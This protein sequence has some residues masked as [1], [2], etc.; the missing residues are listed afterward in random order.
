[1]RPAVNSS[2]R[3]PPLG[4]VLSTPAGQYRLEASLCLSSAK[5]LAAHHPYPNETPHYIIILHSIELGLKAFLIKSGVDVKTLSKN[6]YR[7]DL[8]A[9]YNEA[10]QRGLSLGDPNAGALIAWVNEWHCK[11]VK[12]RYEFAGERD[13][14]MCAVLIPLAE[15][16]ITACEL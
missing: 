5:T 8:C 14:P 4:K 12:I 15:A 6:P 16:I 7:H 13:L 1:M 2:T 10:A 9:L 3:L 11:G